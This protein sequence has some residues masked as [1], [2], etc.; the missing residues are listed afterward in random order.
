MRR[1]LLNYESV[2]HIVGPKNKYR[3]LRPI[4]QDSVLLF[5]IGI[6]LETYEQAAFEF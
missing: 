4:F 6:A 1:M 2:E 3:S 5:E